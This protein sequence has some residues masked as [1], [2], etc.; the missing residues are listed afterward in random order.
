MAVDGEVVALEGKL[1]RYR[2]QA[3]L[4]TAALRQCDELRTPEPLFLLQI[5]S[6]C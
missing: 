1:A 2:E 6:P 5:A 4:F 3:R